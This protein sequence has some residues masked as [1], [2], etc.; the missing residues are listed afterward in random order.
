MIAGQSLWIGRA[1]RRRAVAAALLGLACGAALLAGGHDDDLRT[2]VERIA[3]AEDEDDAAEAA[4]KLIATVIGPVAEALGAME[5]RPAEEQVRVRKV[6][7]RLGAALRV[8]LLRANLPEDERKLIDRFYREHPELV[9]RLFDDDYRIRAAAV[10]QVPLE[11]GTGAAVLILAKIDDSDETVVDAALEAAGNLKDPLIARGLVRWLNAVVAAIKGGHYGP[12]EQ[13]IVLALNFYAAR[14]I[15]LLGEAEARDAT[16]AVV[17]A[18]R[19]FSRGDYRGYFDHGVVIEALAK[20]GDE[21]GA[22][23]LVEMMND[24][25]EGGVARQPRLHHQVGPGKAAVQTLGDAALLALC[26]IYQIKPETL[27]F[28]VAKEPA[29]FIGFTDE[30]Q[31]EAAYRAF[32]VWHRENGAK[33]SGERKPLTTQPAKQP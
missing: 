22:A 16:P 27:G 20:L 29:T 5:Q 14:V 26:R 12:G 31:R 2:L 4:D 10:A 19:F 13:D 7:S 15:Q 1:G 9:E 8:R 3:R 24:R 17:E 25:A 21:R 32:L 11:P 28:Y 33:P 18:V 23:L 30:E 6:L